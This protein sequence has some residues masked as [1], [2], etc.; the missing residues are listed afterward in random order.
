MAMTMR[1][2]LSFQTIAWASPESLK[3]AVNESVKPIDDA[4]RERAT[5]RM[6]VKSSKRKIIKETFLPVRPLYC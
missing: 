4:P 6:P 3:K 2:S 5:R 1:G